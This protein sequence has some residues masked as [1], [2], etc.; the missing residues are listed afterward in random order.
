MQLIHPFNLYNVAPGAVD[1]RPHLIQ[2]RG[3][4]FYL[5]LLGRILNNG[6]PLSQGGGH[7]EILCRSNRRQIQVDLCPAKPLRFSLHIAVNQIDTRPHLRQPFQVKINRASADGASSG[8]GDPRSA[9]TA[10]K[11]PHD[12]KRSAHSLDQ[13]I[14][15]LQL[16][17]MI[18]LEHKLAHRDS[19]ITLLLYPHPEAGEQ[20]QSSMDIDQVRD[21]L[22]VTRFCRQ[23]GG[24]QDRQSGVF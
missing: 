7:H 14:G 21:A 20:L 3:Q 24:D 4:L 13:I 11:R 18:R 23:K 22:I 1:F 12:Q 15:R 6:R 10:E 8:G 16:V 5:R 17:H 2:N 9:E 19:R